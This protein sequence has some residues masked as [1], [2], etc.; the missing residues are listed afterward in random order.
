MG[1]DMAIPKKNSRATLKES[2]PPKNS[3]YISKCKFSNLES[4]SNDN[5]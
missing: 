2:S 3:N 5:L 4:R 1:N